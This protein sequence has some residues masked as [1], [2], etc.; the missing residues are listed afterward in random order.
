MVT[1][2]GVPATRTLGPTGPRQPA[3]NHHWLHVATHTCHTSQTRSQ[4]WHHLDSSPERHVCG[5]QAT[6]PHQHETS[7]DC[8]SA[9]GPH[10]PTPPGTQHAH[11]PEGHGLQGGVSP[12]LP[13]PLLHCGQGFLVI[14]FSV[15][16]FFFEIQF[17]LLQ[18]RRVLGFVPLLLLLEDPPKA[19]QLSCVGRWGQAL[20][21]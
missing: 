7:S 12:R 6:R 21:A 17:Q 4:L 3:P 14:F 11:S 13:Q 8:S 15:P 20:C 10:V 1:R 9:R 5:A 2:A 19:R 18:L 16:Q